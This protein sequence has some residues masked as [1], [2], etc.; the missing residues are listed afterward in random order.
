MQSHFLGEDFFDRSVIDVAQEMLGT[1][2]RCRQ[3]D[4]NVLSMIVNET[5]AYD[6][7]EDL[8]CHASKG[9]TPRNEVMYG[10]A[11]VFICT[12]VMACIG[13]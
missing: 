8:A 12:Y 2:L 7:E 4:G 13:C 1:T 11:G 6:G 5:E 9:K 10:P 3:R